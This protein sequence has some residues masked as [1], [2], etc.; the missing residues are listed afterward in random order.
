MFF[1][2]GALFRRYPKGG[3]M[4]LVRLTLFFCLTTIA[5]AQQA[6]PPGAAGASGR[7]GRG[8]GNP[9][10]PNTQWVKLFNGVDLTGWEPVGAEK[11]VVENGVIHGYAVTN[12]Y[13]YLQA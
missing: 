11:W 3:R 1:P 9:S 13:G 2:T 4:L 7:S 10:L 5:F 12:A 8:G 6:P